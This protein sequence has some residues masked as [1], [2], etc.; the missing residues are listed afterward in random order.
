MSAVS[1][2]SAVG[3]LAAV[4]GRRRG[5]GRVVQA[6]E[7]RLDSPGG[8]VDAA[9]LLGAASSA[10][11]STLVAATSTSIAADWSCGRRR[12][13]RKIPAITAT[14]TTASITSPTRPAR[15]DERRDRADRAALAG[16]VMNQAATILPAVLH[17]IL[18]PRRPRPAPMIEPLATCV[19]ESAKPRWLD[20]STVA[21]VDASAEKP[22]V[23][24][25][26]VRPPP[27]VWMMRQP[28][29]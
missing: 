27:M 21:V 5:G 13:S 22:W 1:A 17:W 19:V 20:A 14:P 3:T 2:V 16:S 26:S 24:L 7:R 12:E 10:A 8:S 29:V 9:L 4:D 28:P 6:H 15:G 23:G 25:T 11:E 18:A